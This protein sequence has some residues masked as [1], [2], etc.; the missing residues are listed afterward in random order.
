MPAPGPERRARTERRRSILRALW[1]GNFA[2]RRVAPRRLH[3]RHAVVTDW[4]HPQWLAICIFILLLC[5]ADAFLT[6]SLISHGATEVN[7]LMDPLVRGSGHSFAYWKFGLTAMGVVLLTVLAR[8]RVW[9]KAVGLILYLVLAGYAVLVGYE[10]F[11]L[12]NIPID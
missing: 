5:S 10:L 12:R 8:L 11:L 2:R 9:G 1:H 4:F 3:E 6:L 7:P